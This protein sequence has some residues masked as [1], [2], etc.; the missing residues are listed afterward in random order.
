MWRSI[1]TSPLVCPA[2]R[3]VCAAMLRAPRLLDEP[4]L[5]L[6]GR[7][8]AATARGVGAVPTTMWGFLHYYNCM[9]LVLV[10]G[11]RGPAGPERPRGRH[12]DRRGRPRRGS[13]VPPGTATGHRIQLH[14]RTA[15]G[16]IG[17]GQGG[18]VTVNARRFGAAT[19][20]SEAKKGSHVGDMRQDLHQTCPSRST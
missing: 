15:N 17:E 18:R 8:D 12:R 16:A 6:S 19:T 1:D 14:T 11:G 9:P 2:V 7:A 13:R 20:R 3:L 5:S 10:F 4:P